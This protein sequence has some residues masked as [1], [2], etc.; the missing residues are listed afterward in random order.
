M[1]VEHLAPTDQLVYLN[2]EI[3]P[4]L[5]TLESPM[6][7]IGGQAVAYWLAYYGIDQDLEEHI[8]LQ[9]TSYD[10]DYC[11][12]KED[13]Q[14]LTSIWGVDFETPDID[15]NTPELG[16]S[17]L[18]NSMKE[19]K[20]HKGSL[21]LDF[22]E[23]L[24]HSKQEPNVVDLLQLPAGFSKIDF[25]N[26]RLEQHTVE[27]LFPEQFNLE[28]HSKLRILNPIGCLKSRMKNLFELSHTKNPEVE[29]VRIKLLLPAIEMFLTEQ[30]QEKGYREFRKPFDLLMQ[31]A[32]TKQGFK[33]DVD[34][35]VSLAGFIN[36]FAD[37]QGERLP[38]ELLS[39]EIPRWMEGYDKRRKGLYI[40]AMG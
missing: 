34:H 33:L 31:I 1:E 36:H 9:A 13:F 21:Y 6:I 27:F 14:K 24:F 8:G 16:R 37:V 28:P 2:E 29:L 10:I 4:I 12:K 20:D 26:N 3:Y 7:V 39:K 23:Y 19:I 15:H 18:L 5:D 35:Q 22:F 17:I 32:K 11:G 25:E 40:A 38:K 30:L